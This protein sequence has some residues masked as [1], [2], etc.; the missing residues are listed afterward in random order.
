MAE[1]RALLRLLTAIVREAD[2]LHLRWA[3]HEIAPGHPDTGY[4]AIRL[5]ER[6]AQRTPFASINQG[7]V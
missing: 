4:I 7:Y 3:Q 1:I 6:I 5:R 2:I